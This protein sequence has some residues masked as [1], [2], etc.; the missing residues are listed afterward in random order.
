MRPSILDNI[1]NISC[2]DLQGMHHE[3]HILTKAI[4]FSAPSLV[5]NDW[6]SLSRVG[7]LKVGIGFSISC[8]DNLETSL[9][10]TWEKK[11]K[12]TITIVTGIKYLIL[13]LTI[14]IKFFKKKLKTRLC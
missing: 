6:S 3:A 5:L 7:I 10:R 9:F 11:I 14:I 8:E 13:K 1:I 2:S 12:N 4:F